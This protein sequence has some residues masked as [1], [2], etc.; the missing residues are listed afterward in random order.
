MATWAAGCNGC[1]R[2]TPGGITAITAPPATSGRGGSRRSRC[3]TTTIWSTVLRYVERNALR[4]ELVARAEDWK[5]SSL[6]GWLARRPVCCG[7][8]GRRSAMSGGWSGSTSRCRSGDLQ[9]L[10][11]SVER[12]RPYGEEAWTQETASRLGLESSLRSRGRP[13][14]AGGKLVMSPFHLC[15]LSICVPARSPIPPA[16]I[17][18]IGREEGS[19][20]EVGRARPGGL[21]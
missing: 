20:V 1:S 15:P 11:Q 18:K 21:G 13:R 2:P 9:R 8:A 3:R 6:P 19:G 16:I 7:G 17:P 10:R 5:W 4:A 12:G 14:K